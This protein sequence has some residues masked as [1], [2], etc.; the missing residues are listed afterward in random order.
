M[1]EMEAGLASGPGA[2]YLRPMPLP[3]PASPRALLDDLRTFWRARPR[4]H[5][6]AALLAAVMT[7]AIVIAFLI[8]SQSLSDPR[9]QII[10]LDSWPANRTDA[11]IRA[12]QKADL[13]ARTRAEAEHRRQ[14]QRLDQNLNRLGI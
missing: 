14:L 1:I 11:Q 4:G 3:R 6:I 2:H 12:Q 13:E 9:E 10:F 7:S 5:W 8:D